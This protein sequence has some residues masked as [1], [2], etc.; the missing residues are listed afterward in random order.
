LLGM[1]VLPAKIGF[2]ELFTVL[3]VFDLIVGIV[4]RGFGK[5]Y[6]VYHLMHKLND[7]WIENLSE[8]LAFY[9]AEIPS[10]SFKSRVTGLASEF[11]TNFDGFIDGS[12]HFITNVC[13]SCHALGFHRS[14]RFSQCY[15]CNLRMGF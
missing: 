8:L 5:N 6:F 11:R 12:D 9:F 1:N 15:A 7:C 13:P 14:P 2:E 4:D 3:L 10:N